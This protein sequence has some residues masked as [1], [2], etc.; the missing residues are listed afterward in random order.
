MIKVPPNCPLCQGRWL[1][2]TTPQCCICPNPKRCHTLLIVEAG[3]G[4]F[5]LKR[6]LEDGTEIWWSSEDFA[7]IRYNPGG[8]QKLNFDPPL[9]VNKE[10]LKLLILFS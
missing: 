7:Q 4:R 10:R 3:G 6:V 8:Y 1:K 2:S 9:D 5:F